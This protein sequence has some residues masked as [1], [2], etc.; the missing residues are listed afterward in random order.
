MVPA[1]W[2]RLLVEAGIGEGRVLAARAGESL[3]IKGVTLVPVPAVHTLYI[4]DEG[5]KDENGDFIALGYILKGNGISLYHSGDTWVTPSL[6]RTLKTHAPLDI[7]MLPINGTDWVRTERNYIGNMGFLDAAK[8]AASLPIDLVFPSHYDLMA[9]NSENPA[10]F[11]ESMYAL[12]PEK[13]FH[14]SALGE[15]FI[16][17]RS[18]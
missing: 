16:Y 7:A 14:V 6:V 15:R 10:R 9:F 5:E 12:F 2:K 18:L 4:Q 13:R 1:P 8:L 17:R 3:D 11:V